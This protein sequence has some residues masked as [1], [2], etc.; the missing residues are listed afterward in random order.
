MRGG[1]RGG[2]AGGGERD[3]DDAVGFG[4]ELGWGDGGEVAQGVDVR[5][6]G[7]GFEGGVV[8]G[9]RGVVEDQ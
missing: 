1:L 2:G 3:V 9:E 4:F 6:A 7:G 8:E 5:V